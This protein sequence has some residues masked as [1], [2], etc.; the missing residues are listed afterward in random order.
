MKDRTSK[1]RANVFDEPFRIFFPTGAMLGAVG[2]S[3][4]P[5]FYFGLTTQYP[6][7]AHARL[8]IE[9]FM[10]SYIF[11]FL[12]TAGPR[13]TSTPSFSFGEL[14][15]LFT[16]DLLAAG[17]HLGGSDRAGDVAFT[18]CLLFFAGLLV[19]RFRLRQD[20][21]PPN[22]VLV[23]LGIL[24]GIG[25]S[26]FAAWAETEQYSSIYR[27]GSAL[28]NES[29][30]LLPIC[31]VAPFFIRRL[32]DL[33]TPNLPE[34]RDFPA[35]WRSVAAFAGLTGLVIIFSFL[36]DVWNWPRT[37]ACLRFVA[38][39]VY[40]ATQLPFRGR[41]FLADCLR[42]GLL[43]I[44]L[45]FMVQAISPQNR[46][47]ALHIVFIMGFNFVTFTVATRVVFG[48]SG[49]LARLDRRP[50]FFIIAGVLLFLAMI[51]RFAADVT[52]SSRNPHL[53]SA[54]ICWLVAAL[55]WGVTVLPK[56]GTVEP[57]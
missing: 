53:V 7:V 54:A 29:F 46:L 50:W 38:L 57:E 15:V 4:W 33:P 23:A 8:M 40:F 16:L 22:F 34:S 41:S 43:I 17:L 49:N 45:G 37:G 27:F 19:R 30:V 2:V 55:I 6:N 48:H 35:G 56:V 13:L 47:G 28:L 20:S 10:A 24:S 32:L 31:G 11:G 21:P 5:F 44:P 3:L 39:A 18:F 52:P 14:M 36:L 1:A 25:G 26:A 42:F 12:G 51:A 9:G